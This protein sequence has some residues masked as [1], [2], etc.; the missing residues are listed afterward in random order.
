MFKNGEHV[1]SP[2]GIKFKPQ[3]IYFS[4]YFYSKWGNGGQAGGYIWVYY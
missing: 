4:L 1:G 3:L 2:W